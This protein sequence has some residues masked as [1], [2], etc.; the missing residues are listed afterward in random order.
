[1]T[2]PIVNEDDLLPRRYL[3]DLL[4]CER[5][6]AMHVIAQIWKENQFTVEGTYALK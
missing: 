3:N 6:A 5:R 4:F 2:D 1:M